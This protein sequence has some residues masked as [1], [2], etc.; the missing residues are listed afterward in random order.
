MACIFLRKSDI[1]RVGSQ[2]SKYHNVCNTFT[3]HKHTHA[4]THA[5]R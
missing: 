1:D 4:L 2:A 5:N 3:S